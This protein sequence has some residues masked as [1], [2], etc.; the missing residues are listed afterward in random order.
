ML[1]NEPEFTKEILCLEGHDTCFSPSFFQ[2]IQVIVSIR[3]TFD[4]MVN[5]QTIRAVSGVVLNRNI[6]HAVLAP[7]ASVLIYYIDCHS[8]LAAML[9]LQLDDQAWLDITQRIEALSISSV[10]TPGSPDPLAQDASHL[11]VNVLTMLFPDVGQ[12]ALQQDRASKLMRFVDERVQ[13]PL[14]LTDV[15]ELLSLS[16]ERTRHVFEEQMTMPFSQYVLW[17]RLRSVIQKSLQEKQPLFRTALDYGFAD[18]SHFNRVFKRTFGT[19]PRHLLANKGVNR[20]LL[21]ADQRDQLAA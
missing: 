12:V 7:D 4:C 2:G 9:Q 15:A 1:E 10:Y 6:V 11:A 3:G 20:V 17:M 16:V 13:Q 14:S 19:Q 8:P 21:L 18:Q 5:G